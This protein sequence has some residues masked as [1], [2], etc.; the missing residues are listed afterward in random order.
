MNFWDSIADCS[1]CNGNNYVTCDKCHG[2][3]ESDESNH[4]MHIWCTTCNGEGVLDCP[5]H[6]NG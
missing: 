4:N 3:G 1:A 2:S 5:N 6:D